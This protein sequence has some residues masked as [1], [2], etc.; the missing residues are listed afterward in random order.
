MTPHEAKARLTDKFPVLGYFRR[1]A[2]IR[3][4][5]S[6]DDPSGVC[7]LADAI[8]D[9]HPDQ[10]RIVV[11]LRGLSTERD[12]DRIVA[13]WSHWSRVPRPALARNLVDLGWHTGRPV[14]L[15]ELAAAVATA[16]SIN[17]D[18]AVGKA[19]SAFLSSARVLAP[20]GEASRDGVRKLFSVLRESRENIDSVSAAICGLSTDLDG[21]LVRDMW[22]DWCTQPGQPN[23]AMAKVLAA[24]GWSA[25]LPVDWLTAKTVLAHATEKAPREVMHAVHSLAKAMPIDWPAGTDPDAT[26]DPSDQVFHA[27]IRS[28]NSMLEALIAERAM[29]PTTPALAAMHALVGGRLEAY[30]SLRDKDGTLLTQAYALAPE[31]FRMRMDKSAEALAQRAA[32]T[33]A[34]VFEPPPQLLDLYRRN[35]YAV[36][37]LRPRETTTRVLMRRRDDLL[38]LLS[39]GAPIHEL[40]GYAAVALGDHR[41]INSDDVRA[42]VSRLQN[43]PDRCRHALMWFRLEGEPEEILTALVEDRL[44]DAQRMW[45]G[46]ANAAENEPQALF[47]LAVLCHWRALA[48]VP[49][50]DPAVI[51]AYAA[52]WRDALRQW[53]DVLP[54][55]ETGAYVEKLC[56]GMNDP[57]IDAA[58]PQV[59]L[60]ELPSAILRVNLDLAAAAAAAGASGSAALAGLHV[61]LVEESGFA[62]ADVASTIDSFFAPLLT[63]I[64]NMLQPLISGSIRLTEVVDFDALRDT[65]RRARSRLVA[66]EAKSRLAPIADEAVAAGFDKLL[67]ET[68]ALYSELDTLCDDFWDFERES[69][70]VWNELIAEANRGYNRDTQLQDVHRQMAVDGTELLEDFE[71]AVDAFAAAMRRERAGLDF[72]T[73]LDAD[74]SVHRAEEIATSLKEEDDALG[75]VLTWKS[76]A[77]AKLTKELANM[78]R[79]C[80]PL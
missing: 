3:A 61:Q 52:R 25:S 48:G 7:M 15:A 13:L 69:I 11:A 71:R 73:L 58:F 14:V 57:R 43:E 32:T 66:L 40:P 74:A 39:A 10:E 72:L 37:G 31:S 22:R 75:R 56:A 77:R 42:A 17:S 60:A 1:R 23:L 4:L 54:L 26:I 30:D 34:Q 64:R 18:P 55:P 5:A 21:E 2:A 24:L 35:P 53:R 67:T 41:A 62:S 63:P 70:K 59:L 80:G 68:N 8:D 65:Y 20:V 45:R 36:L 46:R 51:E 12:S 27:W 33:R 78:R 28:G 49:S 79:N 19:A 50:K 9:G 44:D 29:R 6:W 47:N 76:D 16:P 38:T